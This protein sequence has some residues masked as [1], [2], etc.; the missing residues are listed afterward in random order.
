MNPETRIQNQA[1]I[2]VGQRDDVMIWRQVSATVRAYSNPQQVLKIGQPGMA[3]ACMGVAVTITPDMVGK[4]VAILCQPE[5]K[6]ARGK[7]RD[8][9]EKWERAITAIGG[10]YRLIRSPDELLQMVE[11]VKNG[12][13]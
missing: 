4:R 8:A 3:D 7:Q 2:D 5:F 1:F 13:W 12:K 11:D 9:Q 10:I 6:T